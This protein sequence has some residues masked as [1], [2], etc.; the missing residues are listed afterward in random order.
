MSLK[1]VLTQKKAIVE[2][3]LK[4]FSPLIADGPP[5]IHEAIYYSLFAGGKRIRPILLL[6]T[7]EIIGGSE[8]DVLPAACAMEMI[9]TSSLILDDLPCMDDASYRRGWETCHK[10]FGESTAILAAVA[11][12]NRAYRVLSE[13]EVS[14]KNRESLKLRILR[15]VPEL[16]GP[17]GIIGGQVADLISEGTKPD[18]ETLEY[19]HSRKTGTLFIGCIR[20]GAIIGGAS[21]L[22]LRALTNFAK[23]LGL[24]FQIQDD[25][26][27]DTG[28]ARRLGKEIGMDREKTTFVS[29]CGIEKAGEIVEELTTSAVESIRIFGKR[30]KILE[31]T[32]YYLAARDH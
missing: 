13:W 19:I 9:H 30:G 6:L 7:K 20:I 12:L 18:F 28:D 16:V 31:K 17:G 14:G 23:N 8:E 10:K 15:E 27:D 24:A 2:K 22:E 4:K 1:S 3:A 26:L 5:V 32:A 25:I 29:F 21:E 11:L